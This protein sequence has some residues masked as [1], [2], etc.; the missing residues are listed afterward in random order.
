MRHT[1]NSLATAGILAAA[2]VAAPL[3]AGSAHPAAARATGTQDAFPPKTVAADLNARGIPLSVVDQTMGLGYPKSLPSSS[4][5][6]TLGIPL[7]ALDATL[8]LDGQGLARW[9]E[10][11]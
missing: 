11:H 6:N 4:D 10:T 3:L 5:H 2:V 7:S 1:T 9:A 8:G